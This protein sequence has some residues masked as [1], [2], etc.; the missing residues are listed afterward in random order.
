MT[1]F[2]TTPTRR[3]EISDAYVMALS[4]IIFFA[5][6]KIVKAVVEKLEKQKQKD[7]IT[8]PNP[9]GGS[10]GLEIADDTE[11]ALTILSCMS[12]NERYLVKDPEIIQ[13]VFGLVKAKIK[14][15]SL[16]LTPN[17]MRFLA[18]KL[19]N[20]NQSL[21][22]KI[23]NVV[24]SSNN[25][26][27]LLAR[28]S[29]AAVIGFVGAIFSLLPYAILMA[30]LYFDATQNCGY[31]CQD[32]FEHL[33]KEGPVR[34]YAEESTGHL[35]IAGND[36]ARQIEIYTPSK[37]SKASDSEVISKTGEIKRTTSHTRSRTKAKQV[38]FSDFKKTDPVLSAFKDLEEPDVPQKLCSINDAHDIIA[39]TTDL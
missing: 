36:D 1:L 22:V 17:M 6:G 33:P 13:V 10:I 12:D 30:I 37:P 28:V 9:R 2:L 18:L 11:L 25:R 19:L 38:K 34:I 21:I 32:Y 26:V 31:K 27:R 5:V 29:G 3:Y 20:N 15:E 8:M 7:A 4:F 24:A 39:I 35:A 16:V 23:G 14:K